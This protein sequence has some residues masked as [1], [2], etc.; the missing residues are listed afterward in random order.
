VAA[1][2]DCHALVYAADTARYPFAADAAPVEPADLDNCTEANALRDT[3]VTGAMAGAVLVQRNR[4]YGFDNTLICELA[5]GDPCLRALVSVDSRVRESLAEARRLLVLPGV[6]GM[7]LME[8]EKGGNLDWLAGEHARALWTAA[9]AAGAVVDV[10]VFPWNRIEALALLGELMGAFP[11]V[12]V[13]LDNLGNGPIESG[14]PDC[15][16]DAAL[17]PVI[18]RPQLT[19]KFTEMTLGR[20]ESADLEPAAAIGEVARRVGAERLAWGSDLLPPQRTLAEATARGVA[21]TEAL[22]EEDRQAILSGTAMRLFG[23]A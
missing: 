7:R 15:G 18:D 1:V 19:L 9:A 2:I 10:H 5:A 4:F 14:A 20:I 22:R 13:L 21:A 12:P 6:A 11:Q 16:L 3:L 23:F 17:D 8:P